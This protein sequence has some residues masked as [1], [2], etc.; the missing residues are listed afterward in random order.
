MQP[1]IA[2]CAAADTILAEFH[3]YGES[4]TAEI[5]AAG[6][7][8][9][10]RWSEIARRVEAGLLHGPRLARVLLFPD[11]PSFEF[12]KAVERHD[13][14]LALIFVALAEGGG[15][16]DLVAWVAGQ[17]VRSWLGRAALLGVENLSAPQMNDE[18]VLVHFDALSYLRNACRGVLVI[19][20]HRA[21]ERLRWC[22]ELAVSNRQ[23]RSRLQFLL[24]P[25]I[26]RIE[27]VSR[28]P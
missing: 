21:A 4:P 17:P 22:S 2:A 18:P 3:R 23:D 19:E 16:L 28:S 6:E 1:A 15:P 14:Q 9:G 27:I 10:V 7:R 20:P 12:A 11:P 5:L 24:R 26:P 8:D 25:K 13:G